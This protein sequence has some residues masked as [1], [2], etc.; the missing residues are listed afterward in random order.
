MILLENE[1]KEIVNIEEYLQE[2]SLFTDLDTKNDNQDVV[3][4]M[5]IHK[6]RI[7]SY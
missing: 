2:V 3:K 6:Q 4:L 7:H 1:N 5:T